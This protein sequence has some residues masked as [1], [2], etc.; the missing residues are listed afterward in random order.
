MNITVESITIVAT[1]RISI[2]PSIDLGTTPIPGY[3]GRY[4]VTRQGKV[5]SAPNSH[6][7]TTIE[8]KSQ[9]GRSGRE[10]GFLRVRLDYDNKWYEVHR[11]IADVFL[12]RPEGFNDV[13]HIDGDKANNSVE[14]LEWFFNPSATSF[15]RD[16]SI[17]AF[18]WSKHGGSNYGLVQKSKTI[19]WVCQ[20]CGEKQASE[21]PSY[22]FEMLEDEFIR[23]CS[24]C[25][26]VKL[27]ERI[28]L[29]ADLIAKVRKINDVEEW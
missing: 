12:D 19:E 6:H 24:S 20:A 22:M 1:Q 3:E 9:N 11:L 28:Q 23:I 29:L 16:I 17:K 13:R 4:Y 21:L 25:Q 5:L 2:A 14:N 8:I 10:D 26:A 18:S 7:K 15:D 27:K